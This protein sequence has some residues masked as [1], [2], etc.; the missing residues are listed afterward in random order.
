MI[1]KII[2]VVTISFCSVLPCVAQPS[3]NVEPEWLKDFKQEAHHLYP[4]TKSVLDIAAS[5]GAYA[6]SVWPYNHWYDYLPPCPDLEADINSQE[7]IKEDL[8]NSKWFHPNA[9]SYRSLRYFCSP[10][11]VLENEKWQDGLLN[12]W[13]G[14]QAC[15]RN[16]R[17]ITN[18]QD[19]GAGSPDFYGSKQF[20]ALLQKVVNKVIPGTIDPATGEFYKNDKH[21]I[22][23]V[24]PFLALENKSSYMKFWPAQGGTAAH[25][26]VLVGQTGALGSPFVDGFHA[27]VV[28][29]TL[30]TSGW[31]DTMLNVNAGDKI[32][33]DARG[34][35]EWGMLGE[36]C[37]ADG[38]PKTEGKVLMRERFGAPRPFPEERIGLLV[39]A[40]LPKRLPSTVLTQLPSLKF[41][42]GKKTSYTVPKG[43]SGRLWL[44]INDS[45]TLNNQGYFDVEIQRV[46]LK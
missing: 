3:D 45:Q 24:A 23:D 32:T 30:E 8:G 4:T 46:P 19:L 40:I 10:A 16:G 37:D 41:K 33:F 14:Q 31:R 26:H 1:K 35:I 44:G 38:D 34:E 27:Q 22:N 20:A 12:A 7:W 42:I 18:T 5:H 28:G 29:A 36:Q 17:L 6:D 21:F 15:Y 39:G 2:S 43:E 13:H 11:V 9:T 25:F